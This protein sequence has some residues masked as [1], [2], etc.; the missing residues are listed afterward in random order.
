MKAQ[1]I[2][3]HPGSAHFDEVTAVGL[4]LAVHAETVF[5]IERREASTAEGLQNGKSRC[6][7]PRKKRWQ[8]TTA[9]AVPIAA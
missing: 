6:H 7:L 2:I 8:K 1:L 4:I 3:T 5:S 9:E